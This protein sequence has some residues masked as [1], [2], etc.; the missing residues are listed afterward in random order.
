[1]KHIDFNIR[2]FKF[3]LA[4]VA[5]ASRQFCNY[6]ENSKRGGIDLILEIRV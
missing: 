6:C 1:M 3:L 2:K 4:F 5:T